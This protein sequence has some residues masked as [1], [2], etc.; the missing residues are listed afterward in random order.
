MSASKG[1]NLAGVKAAVAVAGP[2]AVDDIAR[3]PE[4]VGHG[5][6][7]LGVIAHSAA[8]REGGAWLD[9]LLAGLDDNRRLLGDLLARLLPGIGY[10]PP[11]GT[12]LVWLDCRPLGLDDPPEAASAARG[13]VTSLTGPAA[14]FLERARVALSSGPA[15][16]TGGS[17]HVR[18]N[19]GTTP[20]VI[21]EAVH[22][23]AAALSAPPESARS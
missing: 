7:H 9:G 1:W 13:L 23:M 6:S 20:E 17:G 3:M 15:F 21:T 22:R 2:D 19:I 10:R 12:Y 11:Q 16:G 14:L 4:E 8:L 5:A 18:M